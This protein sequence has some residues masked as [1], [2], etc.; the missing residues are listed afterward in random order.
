M[1]DPIKVINFLQDFGCAKL[2]HLQI[3]FNDYNNNFKNVLSSNMVSKKDDI[4]VHNTKKIDENRLIALD[5]L[6]QYKNRLKTF[7]LGI[8]PIQITFLSNE[9]F[10]YHIIVA[11]NEIKEAI[12]NI[13]NAYPPSLPKADRLILV[14]PDGNE[15]QNL[16]CK[17]PAAFVTYPDYQVLN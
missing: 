12:I 9:N 17:I 4:F 11:D 1:V 8:F 14:F 16:N 13:V 3:L 7:H 5:I 10:L 15:L 2:E 6:C